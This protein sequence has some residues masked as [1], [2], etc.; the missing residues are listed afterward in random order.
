MRLG[1]SVLLGLVLALAVNW[2]AFSAIIRVAP[3]KNGRVII[4]VTG[5]LGTGDADLFVRAVNQAS[6]AGK[7]IDIVQL[8]SAG[9]KLGEGAKLATAIKSGRLL[10]AVPSGAVCASACFLVFA[11]GERK[12]AEAG[13][14]IGVHKAS[15]RG[16]VETKASALASVLMARFARELGVSSSIV[17]RMLATPPTRIEWL[18]ARDLHSMGVKTVSN[19]AQAAHAAAAPETADTTQDRAAEQTPPAPAVAP[20]DQGTNRPSWNAFIG[21]VMAL[22]AEQNQGSPA[23]KRSCKRE[24]KE[25]VMAVAFVLADGRHGL[26]TMVQDEK[27]NVTT[28]EVCES[29]ASNDAR[30]CMDWDTGSTYRDLKNSNGEWVQDVAE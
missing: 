30:D 7:S 10:T 13:A 15:E 24:S 22:S 25:C 14:L 26:A 18:D 5:M 29:N 11:A 16:G 20:T 8:N 2:P 1:R 19:L 4:E 3:G 17:S 27:G 12:F 9:G 21:K 28:R 6:Q 23:M